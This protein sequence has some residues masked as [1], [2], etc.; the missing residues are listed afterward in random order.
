[1]CAEGLGF[2]G[3]GVEYGVGSDCPKG[4]GFG[5]YD[6]S[7]DGRGMVSIQLVQRESGSDAVTVGVGMLRRNKLT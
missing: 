1:M 2:G 5:G 4:L 3:R 7:S 6:A